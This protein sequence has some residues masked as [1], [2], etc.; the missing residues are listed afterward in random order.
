LEH[1]GRGILTRVIP[2]VKEQVWNV[3]SGG[4][5]DGK[6]NRNKATEHT[7]RVGGLWREVQVKIERLA[8]QR[9]YNP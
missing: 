1:L 7:R 5:R 4:S 3:F 9:G 8:V 2:K 6:V